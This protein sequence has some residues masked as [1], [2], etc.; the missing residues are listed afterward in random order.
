MVN[1][2]LKQSRIDFVLCNR[3]LGSFIT[4]VFYKMFSGSDHD[5]LNVIIDYC[6][7]ERGPGVWVFNTE[8]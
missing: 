2:V 4:K 5:F 6:G 3:Q 1:N 7:V 8:L